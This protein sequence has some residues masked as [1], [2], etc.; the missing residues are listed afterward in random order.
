MPDSPLALDEA[1]HAVAYRG[2]RERV[3]ELLRTAPPELLDAIAPA[4]PLWRTRDI[5]SHIVGVATD[6]VNGNVAD[7]AADHWT[8]AQV[9]ARFDRPIESLI[10]EWAEA[11][12]QVEA[13]VLALPTSITGQLVADAV[14]HEHDLR[15][16]L[17]CPGARHSDA[18]V[19]AVTWV[20]GALGQVYDTAGTPSTRFES[21]TVAATAGTG[22]PD[23]TV[24]A[25][26]FELGRAIAG[27]RTLAEIAA[28][29]WTPEPHPERV[30]ALPFF[31][32][33]AVSL[34]E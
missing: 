25:S 30:L 32:P 12:P 9:A 3:T 11:G 24:R 16:A 22:E 28:Y 18:L 8:A 33:P 20:I 14:T 6:V 29:D 17:G 7:A 4:T 31:T 13:I 1:A 34:G 27:R 10:D 23:A 21:D 19:I 26:T 5:A 2:V 15:N